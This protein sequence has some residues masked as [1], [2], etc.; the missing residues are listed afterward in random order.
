MM[1]LKT[2]LASI[3]RDAGAAVATLRTATNQVREVLGM[4]PIPA[5]ATPAPDC[6]ALVVQVRVAM[7][8]A[9]QAF[10]DLR[11]ATEAVTGMTGQTQPVVVGGSCSI[12]TYEE[13]LAERQDDEPT[14]Q[15][16]A[17]PTLAGGL[18][19]PIAITAQELP[20]VDDGRDLESEAA[21]RRQWEE[22]QAAELAAERN[23]EAEALQAVGLDATPE[24]EPEPQPEPDGDDESAVEA[25]ARKE[26]AAIRDSEADTPADLAHTNRVAAHLN[27]H[28]PVGQELEVIGIVVETPAD[29]K[30]GGKRK[31]RKS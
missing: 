9:A 3:T 31:P 12:P 21:T 5:A 27:G 26:F 4:E 18:H 30:R 13:Y 11:T 25:N 19:T 1:N 29:G 8:Q 20:P 10:S 6:L 15:P 28:V 23:L 14:P 2:M 7:V 17:T 16:L 22:E 24:P